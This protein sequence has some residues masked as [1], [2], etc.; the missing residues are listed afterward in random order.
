MDRG[1]KQDQTCCILCCRALCVSTQSFIMPSGS[2]SN[3]PKP[4]TVWIRGL[5]LPPALSLKLKDHGDFKIP[6]KSIPFTWD[7]GLLAC[8]TQSVRQRVDTP[9]CIWV[10][11]GSCDYKKKKRGGVGGVPDTKYEQ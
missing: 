11:G 7:A 9:C 4:R 10:A 5:P 3:A 1:Q 2:A 8:S 6:A